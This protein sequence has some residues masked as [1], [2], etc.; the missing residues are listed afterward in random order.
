MPLVSVVVPA[1]NEA[2]NLR[3]LL[4]ALGA[5]QYAGGVEVIVVDDDS[6]DETAVIAQQHGATVLALSHLPTGW[7]GKTNACH[8][9]AQL[10]AGEWLL[11]TDADT[12]HTPEGLHRVMVYVQTHQLDALS[13]FLRQQTDN[14][15]VKLVLTAA[16]AG[17]FAGLPQADH[18]FNGQYILIK[19]VVY[20]ES[21]GFAAVRGEPLEDLAFGHRLRSL[22]YRVG[23]AHGETVATVQMY[24]TLSHL[25]QGMTRI[26]SGS[27]KWS[28][29]GALVTAVLI[30]AFMTPMLVLLAWLVGEIGLNWLIVTWGTAVL[31]FLPWAHRYGVTRWAWLAPLGATLV[32]V[33]GVW[34][35]IQHFLGH[36]ISWKGRRV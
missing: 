25:W 16:F 9:G 31:A 8:Q 4:P 11:F 10:A 33:A 19:K 26:G 20:Q 5:V 1:R 32:Q 21:G 13:L 27:L 24:Q 34:G 2:E 28:G 35:L 30:T 3:R 23:M 18:V 17:L 36:G 22:G 12:V 15:L 7:L 6:G 29:W 14:W